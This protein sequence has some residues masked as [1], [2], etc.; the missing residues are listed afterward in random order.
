MP[1]RQQHPQERGG[2][3]ATVRRALRSDNC[4]RETDDEDTLA[5]QV[6][7]SATNTTTMTTTTTTVQ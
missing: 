6:T 7:I 5:D 2:S 3:C 4:D 1:Q